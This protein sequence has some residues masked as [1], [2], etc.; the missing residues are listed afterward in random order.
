VNTTHTL[1][2]LDH[3]RDKI[4]E[5]IPARS[6]DFTHASVRDY[7]ES[8]VF[9]DDHP[10]IWYEKDNLSPVRPGEAPPLKVG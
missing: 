8:Q 2:N 6:A 9:V 4:F 7:K 10:F 3:P 1:K 5:G